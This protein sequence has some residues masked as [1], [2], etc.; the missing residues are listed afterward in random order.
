MR[1]AV[2]HRNF[3]E[4]VDQARA[5]LARLAVLDPAL[6]RRVREEVGERALERVDG[7]DGSAGAWAVWLGAKYGGLARP[8]REG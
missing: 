3:R 5:Q 4:E 8:P 7:A 6:A 2:E 1:H